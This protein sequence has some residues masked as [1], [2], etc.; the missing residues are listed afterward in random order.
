MYN[1]CDNDNF[2]PQIQVK[3][4]KNREAE[5]RWR[6]NSDCYFFFLF[7]ICF[8]PR[9]AVTALIMYRKLTCPRSLIL[10]SR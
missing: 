3:R 7:F 8:L 9:F 10:L 4:E 2:F 6:S 5:M 1:F